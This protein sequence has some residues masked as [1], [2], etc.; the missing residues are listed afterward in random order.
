M[1]SV[2]YPFPL[3]CRLLPE[4]TLSDLTLSNLTLSVLTRPWA[5]TISITFHVNTF[6]QTGVRLQLSA[7]VFMLIIIIIIIIIIILLNI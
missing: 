2:P 4:F 3:S 7:L 6:I 1:L 5:H